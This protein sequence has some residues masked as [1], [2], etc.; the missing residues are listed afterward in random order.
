MC[1]VAPSTQK[2]S[3]QP[4]CGCLVACFSILSHAHLALKTL[5][6]MPRRE[7]IQLRTSAWLT[8]YG[9]FPRVGPTHASPREPLPK[10]HL[11]FLRQLP[12]LPRAPRPRWFSPLPP[13]PRAPRAATASTR[14][15]L[16]S[17]RAA[18]SRLLSCRRLAL[19]QHPMLPRDA[20]A[21]AGVTRPHAPPS[22]STRHHTPST[23][24][25]GRRR[26]SSATDGVVGK[27]VDLIAFLGPM[28]DFNSLVWRT[29]P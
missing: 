22:A 13:L 8:S 16:A 21:A 24:A 10:M 14:R 27:I 9:N 7:E 11:I 2:F 5:S 26:A 1:L 19:A 15:R 18:A 29:Y 25:S 23:G 3:S 20:T 12:R 28:C 17:P 6:A 4:A